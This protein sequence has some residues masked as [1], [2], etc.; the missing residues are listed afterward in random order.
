MVV[1]SEITGMPSPLRRALAHSAKEGLAHASIQPRGE[2]QQV[3]AV[4]Q[5]VDDPVG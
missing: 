3:R 4:E 5:L 2:E 1:E